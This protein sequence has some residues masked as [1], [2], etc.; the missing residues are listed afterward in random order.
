[1]QRG[2][3]E[4]TKI[5]AGCAYYAK[6]GGILIPRL[7]DEGKGIVMYTN[8][9]TG[10]LHEVSA[11]LFRSLTRL[12]TPVEPK[13]QVESASAKVDVFEV[14]GAS[15]RERGWDFL[16]CKTIKDAMAFVESDIDG[17][18]DGDEVK[19]VFRQYTKVQMDEVVYE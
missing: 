12:P 19:I 7:V 13:A 10:D 9:I 15:A 16:V 1:M 14:Y 11:E 4:M 18:E 5:I 8:S 2:E 17:L 3:D 6:T